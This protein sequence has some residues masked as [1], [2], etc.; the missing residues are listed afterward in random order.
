MNQEQNSKDEAELLPEYAI[1]YSKARKNPYAEKLA[2]Q[3]GFMR[4]G[5]T[6]VV[7]LDADVAKVFHDAKSLNTFLRAAIAA[8]PQ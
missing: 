5:D 4:I 6:L 2:A 1:D 8:M 3:N 7:P